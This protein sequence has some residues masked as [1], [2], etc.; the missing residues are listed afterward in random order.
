MRIWV[1]FVDS[2]DDLS[3]ALFV[4]VVYFDVLV[5]ERRNPIA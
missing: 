1:Y 4:T 2:N 5:K 3:H